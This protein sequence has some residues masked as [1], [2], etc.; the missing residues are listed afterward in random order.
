MAR[1]VSVVNTQLCRSR[2]RLPVLTY[3]AVLQGSP[4]DENG[5]HT[6]FVL[7]AVVSWSLLKRKKHP[8]M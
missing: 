3:L 1:M 4:T 2:R 7:Q 8:T 5:L 6:R